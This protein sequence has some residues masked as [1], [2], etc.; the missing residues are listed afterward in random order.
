[1]HSLKVGFLSADGTFERLRDR[2][3]DFSLTISDND[4]MKMLRFDANDLDSQTKQ[5]VI[6]FAFG[7]YA[8]WK[9]K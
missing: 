2:N 7:D 3:R 8:P 6:K 1:M 9:P 5:L 4:K